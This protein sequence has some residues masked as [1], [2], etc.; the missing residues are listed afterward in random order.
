MLSNQLAPLLLIFRRGKKKTA[1]DAVLFLNWAVHFFLQKSVKGSQFQ[2]LSHRIT[3]GL[4]VARQEEDIL[5]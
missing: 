3:Q 5:L 2:T 1:D 4:A